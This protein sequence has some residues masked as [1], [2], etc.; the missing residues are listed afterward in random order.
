MLRLHSQLVERPLRRP[1]DPRA[2]AWVEDLVL[3]PDRGDLV[4]LLLSKGQVVAPIDLLP[5]KSD[6]W[7]VKEEDAI[8]EEEDLLRLARISPTRR[9]LLLKPVFTKEGTYLGK[10][11]DYVM[12]MDTLSLTH[13]YVTK[14][15][16]G[17]VMDQRIL[18]WKQILEITDKA[19]VV[20]DDSGTSRE[21][22]QNFA[23]LRKNPATP[24]PMARR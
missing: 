16:L 24:L 11:A 6:T 12:D 19:V 18:E 5:W 4:A 1:D 2:I 23:A 17:W 21:L 20:R 9:A 14:S 15:F 13:L 22:L 10:V 7:E 8:L 3:D